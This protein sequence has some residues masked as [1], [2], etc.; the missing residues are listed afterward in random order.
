MTGDEPEDNEPSRDQESENET[1][2]TPTDEE[3]YGSDLEAFL[4]ALNQF[5]HLADQL[6]WP[7][8][9]P[10]DEDMDITFRAFKMYWRQRLR[11]RKQAEQYETSGPEGGSAN[12]PTN[13]EDFK[14][15][16]RSRYRF[17]IESEDEVE[18]EPLFIDPGEHQPDEA[19]TDDA[20]Q[21]RDSEFREKW[22]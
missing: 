4:V 19:P 17:H 20:A 10:L 16:F 15:F 8:S 13:R 18:D 2:P 1:V 12:V 3:L 14:R 7:E 22:E 6:E 21:Q 5:S 9:M 11:Q